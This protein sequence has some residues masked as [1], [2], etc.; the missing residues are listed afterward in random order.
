MEQAN[1]ETPD[2]AQV[3]QKFLCHTSADFSWRVEGPVNEK[4]Q[5]ESLAL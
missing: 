2:G 1:H 3:S 4:G 5:Q